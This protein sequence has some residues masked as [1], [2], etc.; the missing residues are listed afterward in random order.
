MD[1]SSVWSTVAGS[2]H[3]EIEW[4]LIW[5]FEVALIKDIWRNGRMESP[6]L[7]N[8]WSLYDLKNSIQLKSVS[9]KRIHFI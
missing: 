9:L 7:K 8:M 4:V 6:M 5:S 3:F 1:G 2:F